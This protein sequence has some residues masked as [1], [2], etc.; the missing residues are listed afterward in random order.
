MRADVLFIFFKQVVEK[1]SNARCQEFDI[2]FATHLMFKNTGK[3]M[4]VSIYLVP[5]ILLCN[6]VFAK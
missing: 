2:V 1:R 3:R 6:R 4:L 5:L